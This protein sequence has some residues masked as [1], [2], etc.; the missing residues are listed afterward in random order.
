[1]AAPLRV[2]ILPAVGSGLGSMAA[3]GQLERLYV[4]LG[5]Y[6]KTFSLTYFSGRPYH[7]EVQH[8]KPFYQR[9]GAGLWPV[10]AGL[11]A[12]LLW[13]LDDPRIRQMNVLRAM[14]LLGAVPAVVARMRWGIPF[15]VSHGADY[16]AIAQIH[17]RPAWKWRWLRRLVFRFAAAVIVPSAPMAVRLQHQ[18]PRARIVHIPNWVDTDL[19]TPVGYNDGKIAVYVG[20]LV[21]EKNL[22]RAA[23]ALRRA[24]WTFQCCG[25]GPEQDTLRAEGAV[26]IGAA[27]WRALP[28]LLA[29]SSLFVLPSLSEGHPKALLE[30][31]A[32]G[33]ACAVSDR[34]EGIIQHGKNGVVFGAEDEASMERTFRRLRQAP[35]FRQELGR[36]AHQTAVERYDIKKV[37]PR[38]I[39]LV[40]SCAS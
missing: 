23:R 30:A 31:M 12:A 40:Q 34:V 22:R 1:M 8:W 21:A 28:S 20:R 36:A 38:E 19:F 11:R 17:G 27:S 2:G 10:P 14:S 39:A 26:C 4:H 32:C 29:G 35:L 5:E 33:L 24:G 7:D 37:L 9:T 25:E 13:P 15:V 6:T 18:F 16:E 3:T